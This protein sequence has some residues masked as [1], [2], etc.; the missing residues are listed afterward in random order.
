MTWFFDTFPVAGSIR[1]PARM[2]MS[3]ATAARDNNRIT[4]SGRTTRMDFS[5]KAVCIGRSGERDRIQVA[6]PEG[7]CLLCR[8]LRGDR[9][10]KERD[11]L[12]IE[13]GDVA[14][15]PARHPIAV[16]HYLFINPV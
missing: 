6:L 10:G 8:P 12:A 4:N 5:G 2:A 3:C 7:K 11:H 15:L 1:L 14:R 16:A 9:L 13:C